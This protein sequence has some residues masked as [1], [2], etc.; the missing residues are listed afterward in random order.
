VLLIDDIRPEMRSWIH[1]VLTRIAQ[2][3]GIDEAEL[4]LLSWLE[5]RW[6]L[7]SLA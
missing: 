1:G 3:D 4:E 6:N 5:G 2:A 7:A